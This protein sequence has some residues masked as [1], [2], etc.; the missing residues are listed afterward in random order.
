MVSS[1]HHDHDSCVL[2]VT[3]LTRSQHRQIKTWLRANKTTSTKLHQEFRM[4]TL[5]VYV[6]PPME[7]GNSVPLCTLPA[8]FLVPHCRKHSSTT[9]EGKSGDNFQCSSGAAYM[10]Q[11]THFGDVAAV[12]PMPEKEWKAKEKETEE[13]AG[14][15]KK[16]SLKTT[17]FIISSFSHKGAFYC[18]SHCKN[19]DW[20]KTN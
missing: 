12:K 15:K 16:E 5:S 11:E 8:P 19:T 14:A 13:V 9:P 4:K 20:W 17:K 3:S 1:Q 7:S 10:A 18:K 6:P 2:G